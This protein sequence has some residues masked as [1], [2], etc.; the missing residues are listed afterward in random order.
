MNILYKKSEP[1]PSYS[2]N[3]R[4][5]LSAGSKVYSYGRVYHFKFHTVMR[6]IRWITKEVKLSILWK[7]IESLNRGIEIASGPLAYIKKI[8]NKKSFLGKYNR[9]TIIRVLA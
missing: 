8:L 1:V 9:N 2:S 5:Y 6:G 4:K 3:V 7:I